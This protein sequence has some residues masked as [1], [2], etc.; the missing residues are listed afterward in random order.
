M[1]PFEI[2][3]FEPILN[4]VNLNVEN[5]HGQSFSYEKIIAEKVRDSIIINTIMTHRK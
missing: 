3:D 4:R 1:F 5:L 2:V